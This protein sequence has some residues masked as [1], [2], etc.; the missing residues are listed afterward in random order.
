M[1]LTLKEVFEKYPLIVADIAYKHNYSPEWLH[2]LMNG[3]THLR[4]ETQRRHLDMLQAYLNQIG[5][6]LAQ[7]QLTAV[8]IKL[9]KRRTPKVTGGKYGKNPKPKVQ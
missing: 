4:P 3:R 1:Q 7:V 8:P 2:S 6:E 9:A 5:S